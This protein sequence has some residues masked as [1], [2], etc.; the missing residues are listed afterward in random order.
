ML[1]IVVSLHLQIS[2]LHQEQERT[3]DPARS[4]QLG[5]NSDQIMSHGSLETPKILHSLPKF[6]RITLHCVSIIK[7]Y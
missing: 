4:S 3:L 7:G 2:R 5:L 6:P 1:T